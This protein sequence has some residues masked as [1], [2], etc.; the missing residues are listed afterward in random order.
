MPGNRPCT[1]LVWLGVLLCLSACATLADGESP[2]SVRTTVTE[3]S[4]T[5]SME[6]S[7]LPQTE[8]TTADP[9]SAIVD[10][11]TA[12]TATPAAVPVAISVPTGNVLDSLDW[13]PPPY[14]PPLALRTSDHFYFTRPIPSGAVNWPHPLYRYGSTYF[15]ENSIHTG[16]DMGAELGTAIV[17]AATGEIIWVG[18]GLY[19]GADNP[20]DPYGLAITIRHDFGYQDMILF[21][22]YG[23]LLDTNVWIGQR[24][25]MGE[26][27][28]E[29]GNTGHST[30]P[31]LHF[32]V[33]LGENRYFGT[34]NPELWMVPPEGWG[35]LAGRVTDT[36]GRPL[37]EY[38]IQIR[39]LETEK[40]SQVWTYAEGSVFADEVY[41]ENFAI[42]DLPGGPYEIKIHYLGRAYTAQM[43]I[44]PGQTNYF[45]FHGRKGFE[46]EPELFEYAEG[47]LPEN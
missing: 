19:S 41:C 20:K 34:R 39:S 28:G 5:L 24:V 16:V 9:L 31:H 33:R 32:E 3:E 42:S 35:V 23:H 40:K 21:T 13:R 2:S 17:A 22:V 4:S 25:Q 12:P 36:S 18:Y 37:Y 30:G 15:G 45:H 27:I 11:E 29:V 46:I 44:L 7:L 14:V 6:E 1:M 26:K 10:T 8:T 47:V 38:L 43:Y